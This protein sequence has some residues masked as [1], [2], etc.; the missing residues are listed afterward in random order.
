MHPVIIQKNTY[1]EVF[2]KK[3]MYI[4]SLRQLTQI[5]IFYFLSVELV[6]D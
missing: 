1:W 3:T 2:R 5:G 6:R 4:A